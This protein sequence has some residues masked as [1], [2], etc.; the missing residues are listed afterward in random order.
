M[1][2]NKH[3]WDIRE[4]RKVAVMVSIPDVT[5]LA[6]VRGGPSSLSFSRWTRRLG[7]VTSRS[8]SYVMLLQHLLT[9][10]LQYT[11]KISNIFKLLWYTLVCPSFSRLRQLIMLLIWHSP[12]F[13]ED[14]GPYFCLALVTLEITTARMPSPSLSL[15]HSLQ[16]FIICSQIW[17]LHWVS[18]YWNHTLYY[19][20]WTWLRN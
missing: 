20:P 3:Q 1:R 18:Q 6:R 12:N 4:E 9:T 10:T 7:V 15:T 11:F 17:I 16:Q 5:H 8:A 13:C 2:E 14:C 19:T